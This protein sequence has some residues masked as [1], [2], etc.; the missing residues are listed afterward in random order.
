MEVQLGDSVVF[1]NGRERAVGIVERRSGRTLSV[2]IPAEGNQIEQV[3]RE[4]VEPLALTF[5]K[6]LEE[7]RRPVMGVSI[8]ESFWPRALG[9]TAARELA[10]L[11]A[12]M[13]RCLR[14]T[15]ES[16]GSRST[17]MHSSFRA[18]RSAVPSLWILLLLCGGCM[19][20]GDESTSTHAAP[21]L[22]TSRSSEKA[23]P[24]SMKVSPDGGRSDSPFAEA[25]PLGLTDNKWPL[26]GEIDTGNLFLSVVDIVTQIPQGW[27][28]FTHCSGVLLSPD[29]VLTAGHCVCKRQE[30]HGPGRERRTVIEASSCVTRATVSTAIYEPPPPGEYRVV[31][32]RD[33]GQVR[34]HPDL[35]IVLD[36]LG[37]VMSSKADLA[38]IV[39]DTPVSMAFAPVSL[40]ETRVEAHESV[41]IVSFG[42]DEDMGSLG[43][44]RRINRYKVTRT[45]EP[46]DERILFHQPQRHEYKGDS[47]GACL[48]QTRDGFTLVGISS[49]GLG[50]D[51]SFTGIQPYRAWIINEVHQATQPGPSSP[52]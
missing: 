6:S 43:G 13:D 50:Q 11:G 30:R 49:R 18:S 28:K 17:Q 8:A 12:L 42:F 38:F 41:I 31:I 40:A 45:Q 10:L 23:E 20:R 39:L 16:A 35:K 29:M 2:R 32:E 1:K 7:T 22:Q 47:G 14:D 37:R 19:E 4:E 25:A 46:G 44:D 52:Q 26:A 36:S 21:S 9:L 33:K 48:R 34:P 3:E 51:P 27:R 5:R 24:S 15:V